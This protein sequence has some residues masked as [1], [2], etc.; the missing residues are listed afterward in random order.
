MQPYGPYQPPAPYVQRPEKD[1][2][3]EAFITLVLYY[4]GL[5]IVG[6]VVN[7]VFLGNARRDQS[8]GIVT[9]NVGCLQALLWFHIAAIAL[10]AIV[11]CVIFI[12]IPLFAVGFSSY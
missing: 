11:A 8:V 12:L 5:G 3:G 1:Y 9:R 2:L 6:L 10:S 4:V 7:I